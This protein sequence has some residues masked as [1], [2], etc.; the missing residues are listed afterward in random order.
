[1][2]E[3][4]SIFVRLFCLLVDQ[5]NHGANLIVPDVFLKHEVLVLT[6][7]LDLSQDVRAENLVELCFGMIVAGD[8]ILPFLLGLLF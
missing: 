6:D 1:M 3:K 5:R 2:L 7:F 4:V 8:Y